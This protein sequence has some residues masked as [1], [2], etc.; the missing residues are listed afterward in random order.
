MQKHFNEALRQLIILCSYIKHS[1]IKVK[2][3]RN[4]SL[5]IKYYKRYIIIHYINPDIKQ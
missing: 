2:H 1:E 3:K 4:I 5:V